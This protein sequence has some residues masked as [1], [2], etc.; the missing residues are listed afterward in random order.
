MINQKNKMPDA[1]LYN[2][3]QQT[4][5][6]LWIRCLQVMAITTNWILTPPTNR[7]RKTRLAWMDQMQSSIWNLIY[8]MCNN[9]GDMIEKATSPRGKRQQLTAT[10][11]RHR[12]RSRQ[13]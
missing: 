6:R 3:I 11:K 8:S 2:N 1:R 7:K 5:W 13:S 10:L 4:M 9:I 12:S